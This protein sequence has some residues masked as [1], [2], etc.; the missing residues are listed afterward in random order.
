MPHCLHA[1]QPF[2]F[3]PGSR[4]REAG[5]AHGQAAARQLAVNLLVD[6]DEGGGQR[7]LIQEGGQT[8]GQAGA[9]TTGGGKL[10]D[11]V[12]QHSAEARHPDH[13]GELRT[14]DAEGG[15]FHHQEQ[16]GIGRLWFIARPV[17]HETGERPHQAAAK[18]EAFAGQAVLQVPR[19]RGGGRQQPDGA[20][21][22][23]EGIAEAVQ[24]AS[25]FTGAGGS[26][27]Q[28][29]WHQCSARRNVYNPSQISANSSRKP[30]TGPSPRT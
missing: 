29:H 5:G 27:E 7:P 25:G 12:R 17:L 21:A 20:V 6:G 11:G 8:C 2:G 16:D 4:G 23:P 18:N 9:V 22:G 26:G 3:D 19:Q 28:E 24:D 15:F 13:A 30:S 1:G 10:S 14:V